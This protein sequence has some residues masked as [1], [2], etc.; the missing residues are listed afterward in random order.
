M[1]KYYERIIKRE[2]R[3]TKKFRKNNIVRIVGIKSNTYDFSMNIIK[4]IS[5]KYSLNLKI[6]ENVYKNLGDL[7]L[8]EDSILIIPLEGVFLSYIIYKTENI[9]R[10]YLIFKKYKP[11][12][13]CYRVS[14]FVLSKYLNKKPYKIDEKYFKIIEFMYKIFEKNEKYAIAVGKFLDYIEKY[15]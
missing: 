3:K 12:N 5:E 1:I 10:F 14:E 4:K 13:I 8:K 9:D 2:I 7:E 6:D 11:L 15:Y